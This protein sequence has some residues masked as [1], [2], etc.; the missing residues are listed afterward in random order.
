MPKTNKTIIR[1]DTIT[2]K[3]TTV[4]HSI[5][6]DKRLSPN[7]LRILISLLADAD[8]FKISYKLFE[9]RFGIS[10]KTVR[11]AFNNLEDC[12]Y[13]KR[14]ELKRGFHYTVSEYG[15]LNPEVKNDSSTEVKT[16]VEDNKHQELIDK[17][18]TLL[19]DY[20]VTISSFL[21]YDAIYDIVVDSIAL[22]TD[23]N[24]VLD[25][26]AFRNQTEKLLKGVKSNLYKSLL[27]FTNKRSSVIS[28]NADKL[29]KEWLKLELY[30][31]NRIPTEAECQKKWMY[32]KTRNQVFKTDFETAQYDKAEEEYYDNL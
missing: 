28:K 23:T 2:S 24:K 10:N 25:F 3:F 8:S 4:H 26:Y 11:A 17:N 19:Q 27:E 29:Y 7:A 14:T 32:I 15:N 5:L 21:E 30:T 22:H 9:N 12:G 13:V 1:K 6:Y 18:E 31:N 16:L 20:L